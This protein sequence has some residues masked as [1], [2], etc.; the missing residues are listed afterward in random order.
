MLNDTRITGLAGRAAKTF[1][2]GG[3]TVPTT[4]NFVGTPLAST[5]V[6]YPASEKAA[7]QALAVQFPK[8]RQVV[9]QT[10]GTSTA[11]T[12]VLASNWAS[13]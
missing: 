3:W 2:A 1:R 7:A 6:F 5:T 12:V 9:E 8:I 10:S 4:G 11:L 13:S